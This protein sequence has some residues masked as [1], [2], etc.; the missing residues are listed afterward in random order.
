MTTCKSV[1][2]HSQRAILRNDTIVVSSYVG[3]EKR[4]EIRIRLDEWQ[5]A[6]STRDSFNPHWNKRELIRSKTSGM[7][8]EPGGP[9]QADRIR[10]AMVHAIE[11]LMLLADKRDTELRNNK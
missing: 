7:D 3:R 2:D 5:R 11:E 8:D 10:D 1:R 6:C 4:G 9:C